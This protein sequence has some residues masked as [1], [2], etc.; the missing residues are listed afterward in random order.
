MGRHL[1]GSPV[2]HGASGTDR[3]ASGDLRD[4][5][6][7]GR[8]LGRV[9]ERLACPDLADVVEAQAGVLEQVS[10]LVVD[11]EG[12]VLVERVE[13]EPIRGASV[14]P[15]TTS[16]Y[17]SGVPAALDYGF[18]TSQTRS[19]E[20]WDGHALCLSLRPTIGTGTGDPHG[21][22]VDPDEAWSTDSGRDRIGPAKRPGRD[23]VRA[24]RGHAFGWRT[25]PASPIGS[26]R[27]RRDGISRQVVRIFLQL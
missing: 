18:F 9:E 7:V 20:G 14:L 1:R 5:Q 10:G 11:L 23:V 12:P 24:L 17:G 21:S 8:S 13:V 2:V 27:R 25:T 6:P 15:A 19:D 22:T 4:H 26:C 3:I 16:A